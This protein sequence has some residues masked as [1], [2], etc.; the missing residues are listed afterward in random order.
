MLC[1]WM[2]LD[3]RY[4]GAGAEKARKRRLTDT[5]PCGERGRLLWA[6]ST[7]PT[8]TA[9]RQELEQQK[10]ASFA[11]WIPYNAAPPGKISIWGAFKIFLLQHLVPAIQNGGMPYD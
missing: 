8:W 6:Y 9:R 2:I 3:S 4:M 7:P 11:I 5:L 1:N 10:L